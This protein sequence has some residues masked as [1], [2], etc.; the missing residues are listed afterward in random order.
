MATPEW[1][2]KRLRAIGEKTI[3]PAV[4]LSNYVMFTVGQ[5]TH[6]YDATTLRMPLS[7]VPAAFPERFTT[8]TGGDVD[9]SA[10]LAVIRDA[11]S[12]V[13]VAGIM[14]SE[15]TAVAGATRAVVLEVASFN[16]HPVRQAS[17]QLGLRT[18]ASAR[19]EKALDT[20][21]VDEALNLFLDLLA[22]IGGVATGWQDLTVEATEPAN[23]V[24]DLGFLQ[25]R[26][27]EA[28]PVAEIESTLG[29]LGFAVARDGDSLTVTAPT[30]RSTGDISLPHDIV[31]EIA[32]LRGY[33][34]LPTMP[35]SVRLRPV[36][37]LRSKPLDRQVREQLAAR[38]GLQEV[39]TYP[40]SADQLL[41]ALGCENDQLVRTSEAPA[42]DRSALRPNLI[43]NLLEA[44]AANLRHQPAV[45]I[46][47]VGTAFRTPEAGGSVPRQNLHLAMAIT[48]IEGAGLFLEAKACLEM[49]R[50]H[51]RLTDLRMDG[52]AESGWADPSARLAVH[53]EGRQVGVVGLVRPRV[54]RAAGTSD[55]Q[56]VCAELNLDELAML[57][58][59]DNRYVPIPDLPGAEFDLSVVVA[60]TVPWARISQVAL[61]ADPLV[62]D[63]GYVDEFR[64]S[65]VPDRHRSLSLRIAVRAADRTLTSGEIGGVRSA[66]LG[67]LEREV[68]AYLR[69]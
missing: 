31:E 57:P 69:G 56:I 25:R 12:T 27:G 1:I 20:Q 68:G 49:L 54:R 67:R 38:V 64:G 55:V 40:W 50:R 26:I 35:I 13:A 30:W 14:G 34:E 32:R 5:P 43:P 28:V 46:F 62:T 52:D 16:A 47:E 39:V 59:R 23:V 42:P 29:R 18:E 36:R 24:C 41:A 11:T 48:G 4:D 6:T 3:N 61:G 37:T 10:G 63:V 60:D 8:L 7:A 9:V 65:W 58:S 45:R 17:Q 44:V 33:D 51:C 19:F 15:A 53:A 22:R 66:V 21:R 2:S